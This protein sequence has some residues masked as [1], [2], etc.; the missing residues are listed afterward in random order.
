MVSVIFTDFTLRQP[1]ACDASCK[2]R[3][4]F[5]PFLEAHYQDKSFWLGWRRNSSS[6]KKQWG[7]DILVRTTPQ[8]KLFNVCRK[9]VFSPNE[10]TP[11]VCSIK[12]GSGLAHFGSFQS[13]SPPYQPQT[14]SLHSFVRFEWYSNICHSSALPLE[15]LCAEKNL[16]FLPRSLLMSTEW[17]DSNGHKFF[18]IHLWCVCAQVNWIP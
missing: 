10:S 5:C 9:S 18:S 4:T 7:N 6:C 11:Y 3:T 16:P 15:L 1:T 8:S 2:N 17:L 12:L 13:N 14:R